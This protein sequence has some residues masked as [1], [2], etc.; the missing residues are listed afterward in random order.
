MDWFSSNKLQTT[1]QFLRTSNNSPGIH[2]K[3]KNNKNNTGTV[4]QELSRIFY[5]GRLL[6]F[7]KFSF[8]WLEINV[9]SKINLIV[10]EIRY[11]DC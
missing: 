8:E 10:L 9:S 4:L 5:E 11:L 1:Q 3:K 2:K 6:S 7:I